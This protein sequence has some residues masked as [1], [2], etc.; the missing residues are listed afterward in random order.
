MC[1]AVTCLREEGRAEGEHMILTLMQ[2]LLEAGRIEDDQNAS[3]DKDT[4]QSC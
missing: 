2:K 4:V 1:V 3:N